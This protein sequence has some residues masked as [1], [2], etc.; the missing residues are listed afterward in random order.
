MTTTYKASF[1]CNFF[2]IRKYPFGSERCSFTT[3]ITGADNNLTQLKMIGDVKDS[4]E[5]II[6]DYQ[7]IS[8]KASTGFSK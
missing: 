3:F 4:T 8:W 2:G 7:I 6:N 5:G 1:T